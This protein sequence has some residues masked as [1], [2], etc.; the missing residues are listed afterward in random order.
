MPT[1]TWCVIKSGNLDV[2]ERVPT[3]ANGYDH[4]HVAPRGNSVLGKYV[5]FELADLYA[6][7]G[8]SVELK[9]TL[10]E[11]VQIKYRRVRRHVVPHGNFVTGEHVSF[12]LANLAAHVNLGVEHSGRR[13]IVEVAPSQWV[14][15]GVRGTSA[16]R[17]GSHITSFGHGG[18]VLGALPDLRRAGGVHSGA[19]VSPAQSTGVGGSAPGFGEELDAGVGVEV[20]NASGLVAE[21]A[22]WR[23]PAS[24]PGVPI[25]VLGEFSRSLNNLLHRERG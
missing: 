11:W 14:G 17:G 2:V 15:L 7:V 24:D 5:S 10:I 19:G 18:H 25:K 13:G 16:G 6:L 9:T 1:W 21:V 8:L 22:R 20:A 3:W 23:V 4:V 12:G